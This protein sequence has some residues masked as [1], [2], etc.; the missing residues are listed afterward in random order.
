LIFKFFNNAGRKVAPIVNQTDEDL[1]RVL[2]I[3]VKGIFFGLKH[4]IPVMTKQKS[5]AILNTSSVA[6]LKDHL[7]FP[8]I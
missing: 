4:V 8:H 3:N 5:G 2:N 6:G 1:T 7:D